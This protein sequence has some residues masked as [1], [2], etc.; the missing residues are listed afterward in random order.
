MQSVLAMMFSPATSSANVFVQSSTNSGCSA[1]SVA[2]LKNTPNQELRG[3]EVAFL[4]VLN[5]LAITDINRGGTP[6]WEQ[7]SAHLFPRELKKLSRPHLT[8][9]RLE[10]KRNVKQ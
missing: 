3:N 5:A 10:I 6:Q 1:G 7:V 9:P 2:W 8:A 4:N